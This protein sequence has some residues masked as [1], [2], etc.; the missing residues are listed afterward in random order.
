MIIE[1]DVLSV[2]QLMNNNSI[3]LL[4]EPLLSDHKNIWRV[5][6]NKWIEYTYREA[7]QCAAVLARIDQ[8][9]GLW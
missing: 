7:N 1:L 4:M 2:V 8:I 6:P 3:N 5:I 9:I